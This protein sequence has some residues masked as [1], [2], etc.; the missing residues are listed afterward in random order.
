MAN[1]AIITARGGSKRIP[2]KNIRNFL[3]KPIITYSIEAALKSG[4]FDEVMVS[5]DSQEIAEVALGCGA[6]VPFLRSEKNSGDYAVTAD[7]I[8]EVLTEY[9]K[10]GKEFKYF[11]CLYPTAPFVTPEKLSEAMRLLEKTETEAV[12]PVARFSHPIQRSFEVTEDGIIKMM[13]PENINIRSQDLPTAYYDCGQFYCL[14][15]NRFL[16]KNKIFA[17]ESRPIIVSEMDFHDIDNEEDWEIAE[18]KYKLKNK[19][20]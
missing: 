1:I 15:V 19:I 3:G 14:D 20:N 10:I 13:W 2:K 9:K 12:L 7:V 6:K 17:D 5:T 16:I 8:R 11:C 18:F 4:L